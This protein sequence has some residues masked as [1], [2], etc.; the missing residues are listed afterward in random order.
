M[1]NPSKWFDFCQYLKL[2]T[3]METL[4]PI[5]FSSF[6]IGIPQYIIE[7][8]NDILKFKMINQKD[9]EEYLNKAQM[10]SNSQNHSFVESISGK[11]LIAPISSEKLFSYR[12]K[13]IENQLKVQSCITMST[14]HADAKD[15]DLDFSEFYEPFVDNLL[16][17]IDLVDMSKTTF[18]DTSNLLIINRALL[19][20]DL[21]KHLDDKYFQENYSFLLF[22]IVNSIVSKVNN[23]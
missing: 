11:E 23:K 2:T 21:M 17:L 14:S 5:L 6:T 4:R 19:L 22:Q 12:Q 13:S 10:M 7:P 20:E 8:K 15:E 3:N 16:D 18:G 1:K 9:L